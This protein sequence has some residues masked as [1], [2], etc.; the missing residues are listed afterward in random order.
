MLNFEDGK[1]NTPFGAAMDKSVNIPMLKAHYAKFSKRWDMVL[2]FLKKTDL[3]KIPTGRIVLSDS[4]YV[5]IDEYK[6]KDFNADN[7]NY[8]AHKKYIDLQ[9]IVSGEENIELTHSQDLE[10]LTPY[11]EEKDIMF[12]KHQKGEL[13]HATP[14]NFFIFFPQVDI[15][16]PCLTIKEQSPIRKVVAKVLAD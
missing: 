16:R 6:T 10:I 13:L 8:E 5:N 14:K 2:D 12:F 7:A 9:Y 4:V 3:K 11:N 1:L 15:H